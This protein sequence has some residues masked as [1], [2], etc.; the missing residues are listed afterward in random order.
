MN[1][2]ILF[3]PPTIHKMIAAAGGENETVQQMQQFFSKLHD[4]HNAFFWVQVTLTTLLGIYIIQRYVSALV[5]RPRFT[6]QDIVYQ[7]YFALG[8][9][10]KNILT[11]LGG[12][13]GC[14]R[15]VVTKEVLWVTSWFPFSLFA[16]AYDME[17]V[18]PLRSIQAIEGKKTLGIQSLVLTYAEERGISHSLRLKPKNM[19]A[20]LDAL[21]TNAARSGTT[22]PAVNV[23]AEEPMPTLGEAI[24]K[25]WYRLLVVGLLPTVLSVSNEIF[26][27]RSPA[28]IPV[29]FGAM[30]FG[31][32]PIM[33]KRVPYA[34]S[35]VMGAVWLGGGVLAGVV[36]SVVASLIKAYNS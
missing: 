12:A 34:Y 1:V 16:A 35:F 29:F 27:I 28:F 36:T 11:K 2:V 8:G 6:K 15:L 18:I 21:E 7:E 33:A 3:E 17:H 30:I 32:W 9:S 22:I 26:H 23:T 19:Q 31:A 5:N 20:F 25:H 24:R 14:L 13:S 10:N 4:P